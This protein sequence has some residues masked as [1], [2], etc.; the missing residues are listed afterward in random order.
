V[1]ALPRAVAAAVWT[2]HSRE[3]QGS[4]EACPGFNRSM[5]RKK[6]TASVRY[7]QRSGKNQPCIG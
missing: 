2:Q 7:K 4:T 6:S 1:R 3:R 5:Q